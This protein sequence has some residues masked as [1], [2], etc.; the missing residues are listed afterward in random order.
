[1][2]IF[3]R[4]GGF[5]NKGAE[6]LLKTVKQ[7]LEKRIPSVEFHAI[8]QG[9]QATA[10][11]HAGFLPHTERTALEFWLYHLGRCP[12]PVKGCR[13]VARRLQAHRQ[14]RLLHE[15]DAVLDVSGY[16]YSD[17]FVAYPMRLA[18]DIVSGCHD[19]GISYVFLPQA[20]GP[21]TKSFSQQAIRHMAERA[22][23]LYARDKT[24]LQHLRSIPDI[25][26]GKLELAPDIVL[27][28]RPCEI[29]KNLDPLEKSGLLVKEKPLV[30][31]CP[32]IR[33]YR[34]TERHGIGPNNPYVRWMVDLCNA[35]L[36][37]TDAHIVLFP[38][39]IDM[40]LWRKDDR[41]VCRFVQQAL[42][43]TERVR[44][45]LEPC[46]ADTL[47]LLIQQL[48]LLVGSRFHSII[49][50]LS[51]CVPTV[52]MGWSHKYQEVMNDAG[53][54]ELAF[55]YK[56][57]NSGAAITSVLETWA[58]REQVRHR[59]QESVPLLQRKVDDVFDRVAEILRNT[60]CH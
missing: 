22:V 15:C 60:Q 34:A 3:L 46:S 1:M 48:D 54:G 58:N 38:H 53:V 33:I 7:E 25:P 44:V 28:F 35:L 26:L 2:E 55:S 18:K 47:K 6:A 11:T 9:S 4:G 32:N 20:W 30:G 50:A 14:I 36:T 12:V 29:H 59:L 37:E 57:M 52:A 10:A 19:I 27:K 5:A 43:T 42:Q 24:S 40:R 16:A 51:L 45:F 23:L 21:F 41:H 31:I 8:V 13:N 49:A 39:E 56:A 17:T